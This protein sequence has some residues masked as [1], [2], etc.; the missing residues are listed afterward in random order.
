MRF[1]ESAMLADLFNMPRLAAIMYMF[2]QAERISAGDR[3][4]RVGHNAAKACL[5]FLIVDILHR[6]RST[7]RTV[8]NCFTMRLMREQIAQVIGTTP[9]HASRGWCALL[10]DKLIRC[11]G[12]TVAVIDEPGLADLAQYSQR[13]GDFDQEWL[14][15]VDARDCVP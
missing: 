3:L 9:V 4:A 1:L 8:G 10:T 7:E 6:L 12:H 14:S 13:D 2:A 11:D 5:A 15:Q